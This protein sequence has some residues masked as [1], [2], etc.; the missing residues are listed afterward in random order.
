VVVLDA[1]KDIVGITPGCNSTAEGQV[2]GKYDTNIAG[3]LHDKYKNQILS[4]ST[5]I[6]Y[7][8]M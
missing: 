6:V 7:D 1:S 8:Q 3:K 4:E 2:K 5:I